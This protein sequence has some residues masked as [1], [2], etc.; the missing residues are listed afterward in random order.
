MSTGRRAP[1]R[2]TQGRI[3][4]AGLELVVERGREGPSALV[5]EL[6]ALGAGSLGLA[7]A[8]TRTASIPRPPLRVPALNR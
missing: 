8:R 5:D 4:A 3:V 2:E 7:A 1:R 6:T